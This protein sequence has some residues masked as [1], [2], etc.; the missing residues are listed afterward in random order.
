MSKIP[1]VRL[2][3]ALKTGADADTFTLSCSLTLL[4][5]VLKLSAGPLAL[6]NLKC[7]IAASDLSA[8][9]LLIGLLVLLFLDVDTK[10][11]LEERPDLLH[12][13]DCS[14]FMTNY[15]NDKGG[16]V[17]RLIVARLNRDP[18]ERLQ[19]ISVRFKNVIIHHS[20]RS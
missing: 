1:P 10:T 11:L 17:S 9:D 20:N 7:L 15:R 13:S 6:L 12:G 8:E 16:R 5:I 4:H 2:Q 19:R 14:S 3:D 18:N